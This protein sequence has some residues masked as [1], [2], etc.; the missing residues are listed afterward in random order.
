MIRTLQ[1]EIVR[2]RSLKSTWIFPAIGIGLAWFVTSIILNTDG[3]GSPKLVDIV[4]NAYSPLSIVFITIP[5]AQAFGH[6]YRDGTMRLTLSAFPAR[7]KVFT[8][9]LVV[10]SVLSIVATLTCFAGIGLLYMQVP[11]QN[12]SEFLLTI[13]RHSAFTV[14]WGLI[15]AGVV[16]FSRNLAAGI[17]GVVVWA[18]ILEQIVAS[19]IAVKWAKIQDYLPLTK[20][21]VWSQTGELKDFVVV[22]VATVLVVILALLKFTKRDA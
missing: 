4:N 13:L 17:A 10:P 20:G 8:A 3:E 2:A 21:M 11:D 7:A 16:I 5:F 22:L 15:A 12:T 19:I 9:K 18:V 1:Y 14:M 6:E